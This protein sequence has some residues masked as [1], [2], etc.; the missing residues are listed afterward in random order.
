MFS[1]SRFRE[2]LFVY[3]ASDCGFPVASHPPGF[4]NQPV[5]GA[6]RPQRLDAI[7]SRFGYCSRSEARTW[8]KAG[9][10]SSRV[11]EVMSPSH[12]MLPSDVLVDGKRV[13]QYYVD[14][15]GRVSSR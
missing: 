11:D 5:P 14:A 8:L 3:C 13:K 15:D 7:L 2:G 9:R 10:V 6:D 1:P 12:R 4:Y